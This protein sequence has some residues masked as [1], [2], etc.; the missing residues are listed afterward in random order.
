[1][2]FFPTTA[3]V[4]ALT[5]EVREKTITAASLFKQECV[6]L[7]FVAT[8]ASLGR[9]VTLLSSSNVTEEEVRQLTEDINSRL[10]DET[11]ARLFFSVSAQ[12]AEHYEHPTLGWE[13]VIKRFPN[14]Q[15]DIEEAYKCFAGV[16]QPS[17]H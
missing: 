2:N 16:P 3:R 11:E 14:A 10:I 6:G 8:P 7:G 1:M 5:P 13:E 12:E 17:S 4:G 9:L 15:E